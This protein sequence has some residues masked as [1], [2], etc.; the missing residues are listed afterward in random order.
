MVDAQT[1]ADQMASLPADIQ[2][3]LTAAFDDFREKVASSAEKLAKAAPN[4]NR[5][6]SFFADP[7]ALLDSV[8]MGY[9]NSPTYLT[10]DTL[11]QVAE[12]DTYVAPIIL[13]RVDQV[14]TFARPQPNRY[15]VGFV[16]RPRFGDKKRLLTKSEEERRDHLTMTL[17]NTGRE[18]NLGRDGLRQFI[19]KFVRDSL[20]YDQACFETVRT[21][22]GG[23]HNFNVVDA[24]TI[25]TATPKSMKGSPPHVNELKKDVKYVQ[26]I[27]AQQTAQFTIDEMAF[28]VRNPRSHIKAYGYGFPEIETLITTI[29]S[30][31]WA[32]EW[33]RRMFSQGS[34]V[35]GVLNV[36]GNLRQEQFEAFK[37]AWHSQTAGVQNSWKTPMLN[38]EEVQWLPLQL[39]NS[40]MG[41][42]MWMEYL[43]FV[44][45]TRVMT[46]SGEVRIEDIEPGDVVFSHTGATRRVVNTQEHHHR[47]KVVN[48]GVGGEVI[49][50]TPEHP[51]LVAE[52]V[53]GRR[54]GTK[55]TREFAEPVWVNACDLEPGRHYMLVPKQTYA[56]DW[57]DRR[58]REINVADYASDVVE[59]DRAHVT[60]GKKF[61]HHTKSIASSFRLD[62]DAAFAL[63]LYAAE[64][65][66]TDKQVFFTF[67]ADEADLADCVTRFADNYLHTTATVYKAKETTLNVR[68]SG[69]LVAELF[70]GLCGGLAH[71]KRVPDVVM[72]SPMK[73][74]RAF[75]SGHFAGDGSVPNFARGSVVAT[76]R[77]VSAALISQLQTI[78]L[79]GGVFAQR[80]ETEWDGCVSHRLDIN[81][82]QAAKLSTWLEGAKGSR[83]R[84]RVL[85]H[86]DTI[87]T[88]LHEDATYFY[89][90]IH[91]TW[92]ENYDGPVHNM[93]VDVDNTYQV[94]RFATHNC[95]VTCA[96]FRIDPS[97]I[98]FDL[99]GGVGQQPVFM[100]TNEAQQKASKDR[101]LQPLLT[102]VED[103]LN[104]HVVWKVDPRWEVAFVGLD[105]KT[106]EQAMQLRQQQSSTTFKLNE[107]R[108]M[109]GLPPV[110]YGD[111]V[112]NP[113]YI[114][115]RMQMM[116]MQAQMAAQQQP[117]QQGQPGQQDAPPPRFNQPPGPEEEHGADQL[118]RFAEDKESSPDESSGPDPQVLSRLH[119]DDWDSV[120]SHSVK[121]DDLR[122]AV[123]YDLID[124]D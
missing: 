66:A 59:V 25:R 121:S 76:T 68:I 39:S 99:R 111:V 53:D 69:R 70:A 124:I 24:S 57:D 81:G 46:P 2:K 45:G 85:E 96:L 95:K 90:P 42:Q 17:L 12:R 65:N 48:I 78:L 51:F 40:E 89:V 67:G 32:E 56:V 21:R 116:Q 61:A 47:G 82:T 122:K 101:G 3:T 64:G 22:G 43:C 11:R 31:L 115:Y 107:V 98:N 74:Q 63:G 77:S 15:S 104:R 60:S 33:N 103:A 34:T 109:D 88:R 28:C 80:Y 117:Q 9:R 20:T 13:T 52:R 93:E 120:V 71:D 91:E 38:S 97:E 86:Q 19:A 123:V 35:K 79:R 26:I 83:L 84:T 54:V 41:Y 113:T 102:F 114:G 23:L 5:P 112:C 10:Y 62:E 119:I 6:K 8:G 4:D 73:V 16:V 36:K 92:T 87:K 1:V 118:R 44:P 18:Y 106:E 105:A 94:N 108:A 75:F 27:N 100:S 14:G 58:Y 110:E 7:F 37:R 30:H 55:V 50:A 72:A 49:R 29:T